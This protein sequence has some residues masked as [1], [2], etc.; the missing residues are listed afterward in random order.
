[1]GKK[2]H[3]LSDCAVTKKFYLGNVKCILSQ[4]Y[5]RHSIQEV[6]VYMAASHGAG[7]MS[8]YDITMLCGRARITTRA[9]LHSA[10]CPVIRYLAF[11]HK[12]I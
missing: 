3:L 12:F 11:I 7:I 6:G 2:H 4:I 9:Y 5:T 8:D 1:M 10:S